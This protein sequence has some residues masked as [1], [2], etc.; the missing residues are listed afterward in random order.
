MSK[1]KVF[2]YKVWIIIG[3]LV[4]FLA[5]LCVFTYFLRDARD[6]MLK[7][8]EEYE[9][10]QK[11][12]KERIDRIETSLDSLESNRK[13]M[14][15]KII[16][17]QNKKMYKG[18][19][20][21][22][23]ISSLEFTVDTDLKE[24]PTLT[25]EDMN[26]LI[27]VWNHRAGGNIGLYGKGDAFIEAANESGYNPVYL[28][29]HAAVE[30]GWG[31]SYLAVSRGNMYGICAFD[32]DPDAALIMGDNMDQGIISGSVW[33]NDNFYE[34]RGAVTLQQMKDANYASNPDWAYDI[35]TIVNTSYRILENIN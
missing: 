9:Q 18:T 3:L 35:A 27:E 15:N 11:E 7:K 22:N 30:S 31:K 10:H 24:A 12:L 23:D 17:K 4:S 34:G 21:K 20:A 6:T 8:Q 13:E 32:S 33:I 14:E 2:K 1:S 16:E 5:S 19:F 29:A 28:L 25:A 26:K